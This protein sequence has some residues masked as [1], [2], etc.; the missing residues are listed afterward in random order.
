M[1]KLF[2]LIACLISIA[3]MFYLMRRLQTQAQS[4]WF[5]RII[6]L[7]FVALAACFPLYV[8]TRTTRSELDPWFASAM[9]YGMG[10]FSLL[11]TILLIRDGIWLMFKFSPAHKHVSPKRR[12]FL[13]NS[14]RI[15]VWGATAAVFGT[16]A[17]HAQDAPN[18]HQVK[19]KIENLPPELEGFT[20]VQISDL[21]VGQLKN[22]ADYLQRLIALVN[23]AGADMI[24]M[25]GDIV[26][27]HVAQMAKAIAPLA[28]LQSKYGTFFVT[29]N[30]EYYSN[31]ADWRSHFASMGWQV[32]ANQHQVLQV[33][34][35]AVVVGG[36]NDLKAANF[37]AAD[38]CDPV[39]AFQGSPADAALKLL[40]AHHPSTAPLT[41]GLQLDLQLSGHTHAGQY[42]PFT[43]LVQWVH[44][45]SQ[46]LN[47]RDAMQV[48]VNS[49]TGYWGPAL[50]TTDVLGEISVIKLERAPA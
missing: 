23:G 3:A 34:G 50:R 2:L 49:G 6:F 17:H 12:E 40:L 4:V 1:Q 10:A 26:D 15:G 39:H 9:T 42:F 25:T 21:H 30:H 16:A 28:Q 8:Q 18:L 46:G 35:H 29:G 44:Q 13:R 11:L 32:L 47:R 45:Y 19:V 33:N 37:K 38:A 5:K 14:S 36:V 48:Y 22:E 7:I 41:D 27:G 31:A 24:A 20:I 43:W